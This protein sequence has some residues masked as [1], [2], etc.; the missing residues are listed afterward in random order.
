MKATL[1]IL[2]VVFI[3]T[4]T[5]EIS[6]TQHW[7]DEDFDGPTGLMTADLDA[8]GDLDLIGSSVDDN[9][10]AVW[11]NEGGDPIVWDR[12][13]IAEN[14]G[15]ALYVNTA[16]LNGDQLPD[17]LGAAW[18]LG[19]IGIW[20]NPGI[21]GE[22]WTGTLLSGEVA[23]AHEV[24]GCD[25]DQD[26]DIDVIGVS[27]GNNKVVWWINS[28]GDPQEW[29]ME[30]IDG[31]VPG[32]R[33][34]DTGDIDGDNITDLA[35][36]ALESNEIVWWRSDG[37]Q[38]PDWTK[39]QLDDNFLFSH[40]VHLVDLDS[41]DDL[42]ILGTAYTA[43]DIAWWENDS[44]IF[45]D[46]EIIDGVFA[47]AVIAWGT[48]LDFDGDID[49]IGSAQGSNQ[50]AWWEND[51]EEDFTKHQVAQSFAGVWPLSYGD[52]DGDGDTDLVAGGR[53]ADQVRWWENSF[54]SMDFNADITTGNKP[55][56]VFFQDNSNFQETILSWSWDFD[57]DG[58]FDA[59]GEN[60]LWIYT[61]EGTYSVRLQIETAQYTKSLIKED[62]LQVFDG[63]SALLFAQ[64]YCY[65]YCDPQPELNLTEA[66]TIEAWIK[67][68]DGSASFN[69]IIDKNKITLFYSSA[70]P[71]FP[72]NCLV[73]QMESENG[74]ISRTYS[75]ENSIM[76]GDWNH[77]AVTYNGTD[78][79]KIYINGAEQPTAN[80]E[81]PQGSIADHSS[82]FLI[83]GNTE[84][85][86]QPFKGILDELRLWEMVRS[87]VDIQM[88]MFFYLNGN[89]PG[90]T[91]NW[92]FNEGNGNTISDQTGLIN[93]GYLVD[94]QWTQGL[95]LAGTGIK[96]EQL[97]PE[98]IISVSC[99]PN[100]FNPTVNIEFALFSR[101]RIE[102]A[103]YNLL[104]KKIDTITDGIL[105]AGNHTKT[106]TASN[107][108]SGLYLYKLNTDKRV[109]TGKMMLLK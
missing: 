78:E 1:L 51:G 14:F 80:D 19:K 34:V 57:N 67:P 95:L 55:L 62:Y 109:K 75:P 92:R 76:L 79:V 74:T 43:G 83:I 68:L 49:V 12:Q 17:V 91:A 42:D 85:G 93:T 66:L 40:K 56:Q 99:Y 53:D 41:D 100:P 13:V 58:I 31:D 88:N 27:A 105:E 47:G 9:L 103:V 50:V 73:F 82:N 65:A 3:S 23:Q 64:N 25:L 101:S 6:F 37:G 16:D 87:D 97:V 71:L 107:L 22:E 98:Q 11:Y 29:Q 2:L 4:L 18:D 39:T 84:A 20:L 33:S 36:A 70:F 90:L 26:Q 59:S 52:L 94:T 63:D 44:G 89:E 72:D 45:A 104:G 48:D 86:G 28:G 38:P 35:G 24:L 102:L 81:P 77:I 46:K 108:P 15:G 32:A 69:K 106:W 96:D 7:V 10:I 61:E 60:P 54:Y 8:D 30:L 21:P 5:A